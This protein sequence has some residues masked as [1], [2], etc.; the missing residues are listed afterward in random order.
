MFSDAAKGAHFGPFNTQ[1]KKAT[2]GAIR[3]SSAGG[4][5]YN[6]NFVSFAADYN[7]F[8]DD[9]FKKHF[10]SWWQLPVDFFSTTDAATNP[11]IAGYGS[12]AYD[13]VAAY[14]VAICRLAPTG[15]LPSSGFGTA[16]FDYMRK[17]LTFTGLTGTIKFESTGN[18]AY[19][20]A[21][22]VLDNIEYSKDQMNDAALTPKAFFNQNTKTWDLEPGTEISFNGNAR[23]APLDADKCLTNERLCEAY[24]NAAYR[25]AG[26][27]MNASLLL[28]LDKGYGIFAPSN[29]CDEC[30]GFGI[31]SNVTRSCECSPLSYDNDLVLADGASLI[32]D[33]VT[34]TVFRGQM[35]ASGKTCDTIMTRYVLPEGI[36][37][38]SYIMALVLV[39]LSVS[40]SVFYHV[41]RAHSVIRFSSRKFCQIVHAGGIVAAVTVIVVVQDPLHAPWKCALE[42]WFL[43]F[44]YTLVF[45]PLMAKTY[46]VGAGRRVC[47]WVC[48]SMRWYAMVCNGCIMSGK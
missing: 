41:N 8:T 4:T 26:A 13:V 48:H 21:N 45:A 7:T 34:R 38:L 19:D 44:S 37:V 20:S 46:K 42:P 43:A 22:Y 9:D 36:V 18:R 16:L 11:S 31:C 27:D 12:Y 40:F 25:Q 33:N 5:K 10:P 30:S 1:T 3:I 35:V 39:V 32:V 14:G 28:Q 17:N 24:R 15:A 47:E 23:V 29:S 6:P 2:D